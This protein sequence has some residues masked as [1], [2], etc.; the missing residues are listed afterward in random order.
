MKI[1]KLSAYGLGAFVLT[2]GAT[3]AFGQA[4]VPFTRPPYIVTPGDITATGNVSGA[5]V[6][7]PYNGKVC[8]DGATCNSFWKQSGATSG[9]EMRYNNSLLWDVGVTLLP[10]WYRPLTT[11]SYF[12]SGAA[13]GASA[14]QCANVGCRLSLGNTARYFLDNG[15]NLGVPGSFQA[16]TS[17]VTPLITSGTTTRIQGNLNS[18]IGTN[19]DRANDEVIV[20][21]YDNAASSLSVLASIDG[22]GDGT[23]NSCNATATSG[24]SFTGGNATG[25]LTMT[26][27][28]TDSVT[29][30]TVPAIRLQASQDI[31]NTD[32]LMSVEDSAGN[33]RM[34]LT[35]AGATTFAGSVSSSGQFTTTSQYETTFGFFTASGATA[36]LVSNVSGTTTAVALASTINKTG[37]TTRLV[38]VRNNTTTE[39]AYFSKDGLLRVNQAN[40]AKPTCNADNRG[41]VYYLDGAA[42]VADTYEICGKD[43]ADVYAWKAIVTF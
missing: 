6:S 25:N 22:V 11:A 27:N 24:S 19:A 15:T 18:R 40:A 41:R 38:S 14:F 43:A 2:F 35:E 39:V 13:S 16:D 3:L 36:N 29:S 28:A 34:T 7:V 37:D 8:V 20:E 9:M 21:F 42:G 10:Y 5:N 26:S 33:R 30:G 23:F 17:V 31:T 1:H 12:N 4:R 32:L